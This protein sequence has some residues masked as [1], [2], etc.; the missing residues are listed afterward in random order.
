MLRRTLQILLQ[1]RP[2]TFTL[3]F[4]L[5]DAI[6]AASGTPI[7]CRPRDI[8]ETFGR[9]LRASWGARPKSCCLT[10]YELVAASQSRTNT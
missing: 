2:S 3:L 6:R 8:S 9:T 10:I 5:G 7:L 1:T 4:T